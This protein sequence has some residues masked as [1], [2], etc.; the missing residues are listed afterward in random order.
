MHSE[1]RSARRLQ[2]HSH[3]SGVGTHSTFNCSHR[4]THLPPTFPSSLLLSPQGYE[5]SRTG[6]PTRAAFEE[7]IAKVEHAKYALAFASGSA[8]TAT[9]I[10]M[11]N[12][13]DHVISVDDVYGG[14]NRYFNKVARPSMGLDFT[15]IDFS[16]PSALEAAI[17]PNT[18]MVWLETPTNPT[19][20]I[21]DITAISAIAHKHNLIVVAD[22][23]FASP[24]LQSPIDLG[25]DIVVHSCTKYIGGHSDVVM[26]V[27]ATS[28]DEYYTKLKF[29]QNSIGA[30]PA[31]FDCYMALRG[32]K[33]LHLRMREHSK[34]AA[35]VA[36]FLESHEG[37][38]SVIYPG[39]TSHPQHELAKRQMRG[40]GGMITFFIKGGLAESRVFLESLR[41]FALAESLGAVESLAEHPVIMTHASVPPEQRKLLGI[42]D[43]LIRLSVG[44]EDLPDILADLTNAFEAVKKANL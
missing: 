15:M 36:T 19:L 2:T 9:V 39:L 17:K 25:A 24:F 42:S 4:L 22:N 11:L 21:V 10:H 37:V 28:N 6:N 1:C 26:G 12:A 35:A 32:M 5:Y 8:T 3:T 43:S 16:D 14:T 41:L 23:T 27:L 31:P 44:C 34:N 33:T 18:K 7:C 13:G 38:E 30:V 40:F 20:K 29:L